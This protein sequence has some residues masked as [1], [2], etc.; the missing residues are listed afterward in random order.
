MVTSEHC[1]IYSYP[2]NV[3]SEQRNNEMNHVM[4]IVTH[5]MLP[6]NTVV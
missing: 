4:F 1:Y 3:K 6:V 5:I 2:Y